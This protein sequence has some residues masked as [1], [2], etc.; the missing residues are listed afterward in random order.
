MF[1]NVDMW[2]KATTDT[3]HYKI[4]LKI[5]DPALRYMMH[6]DCIKKCIHKFPAS[7]QAANTVLKEVFFRLNYIIII[8]R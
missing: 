7:I 5:I 4:K 6:A 8:T 3:K 1:L 2:Y